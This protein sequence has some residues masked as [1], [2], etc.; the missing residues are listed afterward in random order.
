MDE[1]IDAALKD[2]ADELASELGVVIPKEI[3][4]IM[5]GL[6]ILKELAKRVKRLEEEVRDDKAAHASRKG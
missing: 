1:R 3:H 5:W 6:P 4:V 2:E